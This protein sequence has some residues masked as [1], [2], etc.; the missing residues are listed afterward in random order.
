MNFKMLTVKK[1]YNEEDIEDALDDYVFMNHWS[2]EIT[3]RKIHN[4]ASARTASCTQEI[5]D[6]YFEVVI[7]QFQLS[8]ISSC[9]HILNCDENGFYGNQGKATV[10]CW[11][12]SRCVLKLI[13]NNQKIH[14]TV[15]N[16]MLMDPLHY[17]MDP[18]VVY[19]AKQNFRAEWALGGLTGIKYSISDSCW[20]EY[21]WMVEGSVY[22]GMSSY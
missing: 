9:Y 19:K 17:F 16:K 4:L 21:D 14:C 8:S 5:I 20:M 1:L 3:T 22:T 15:N 12:G 11:K 2:K 6:N 7:K 10:V 13:G 18:F